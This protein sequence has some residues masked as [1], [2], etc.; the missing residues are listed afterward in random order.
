MFLRLLILLLLSI[1]LLSIN[2]VH[3]GEIERRNEPNDQLQNITLD[4]WVKNQVNKSWAILMSN[5]SPQG[6]LPGLIVASLT[7]GHPNYFFSWTRDT[8]VVLKEIISRYEETND[9]SLLAIIKQTIS[10]TQVIQKGSL[11]SEAN[12]GEPKYEVNGSPYSGLWYRPQNDGPAL[13]ATVYMKFARVYLKVGGIEALEYVERVLYNSNNVTGSVIKVDLEYIAKNWRGI[14]FD[15]WEEVK[16]HHFFTFSVIQRALKEG[17][18]FC[19]EIKDQ[20]ASA[21]YQEQADQVGE[22]LKLFWDDQ[23]KFVVDSRDLLWIYYGKTSGL[24]VGTILG[25]LHS[26]KH[27]SEEFRPGSYKMTNTFKALLNSM[28]SLY[29]LNQR[30]EHYA[31]KAIGRYPEDVYDGENKTH[32]NPWFI[33]TLAMSEYLYRTNSTGADVNLFKNETGFETRQIADQFLMI[34][35]DSVQANGSIHEGFSRIDGSGVGARDLTWSH[36]AFLSM[37]RARRGLP[38]F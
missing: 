11:S 12:M 3:C 15:L 17:A 36:V 26:G 31:A 33:T 35:K 28:N 25:C 30:Y 2:L 10:A 7:T 24:D 32:G 19:Q 29:P 37:E 27:V 14:S 4:E 8:A 6:A 22:Q 5:V 21:F 13:R 18:Q 1:N 20:K 16:G 38:E 23:K 9:P 34:V